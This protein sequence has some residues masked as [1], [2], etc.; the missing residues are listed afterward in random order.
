LK[1]SL[2]FAI[3]KKVKKL[4]DNIT[5]PIGVLGVERGEEVLFFFFFDWNEKIAAGRG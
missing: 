4:I 2:R 3:L 1:N 5:C